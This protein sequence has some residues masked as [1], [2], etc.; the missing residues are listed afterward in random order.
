MLRRLSST[1]K[2]RLNGW[3]HSN[4]TNSACINVG[5][6]RGSLF[7]NRCL[8]RK[9]KLNN[10]DVALNVLLYSLSGLVLSIAFA[11]RAVTQEF[12]QRVTRAKL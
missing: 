11:V 3:R 5:A 9:R 8:R 2:Q 10:I 12:K 1:S 7:C 6:A 4:G